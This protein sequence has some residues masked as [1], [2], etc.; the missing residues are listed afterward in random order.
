M[1]ASEF[2]CFFYSFFFWSLF[3]WGWGSRQMIG[4][5]GERGFPS[6]DPHL[7]SFAPSPPSE[8]LAARGLE[9]AGN[10]LEVWGG[11][12]GIKSILVF[13]WFS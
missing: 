10:R 7:L 12:G 9:G 5:V 13:F 4:W 2:I 1:E 6:H 11:G 8:P 3:I